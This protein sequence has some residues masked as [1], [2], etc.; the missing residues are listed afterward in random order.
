MIYNNNMN[1][2]RT[3]SLT[4]KLALGFLLVGI[5]A[6]SFRA[7]LH[8]PESIPTGDSAWELTI[9]V[10]ISSD[11]KNP[12]IYMAVPFDSVSNRIIG[13]SFTHPGFDL[14]RVTQRKDVAAREV[15]AVARGK[16]ELSLTGEFKIH[17]SHGKRWQKWLKGS[18]LMAPDDRMKFLEVPAE[19]IIDDGILRT[20]LKS[21]IKKTQSQESLIEEIF[22][23]THREIQSDKTV[24]FES[25]EKTLIQKRADALGKANAMIALCR[26]GNI[27]ARLVTGVI[28][29][30]ILGADVHHWVEVYMNEDWVPYD[31]TVGHSGAVPTSYLKLKENNASLRT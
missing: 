27:P 21:L 24:D 2:F 30:E 4:I 18:N 13:Q 20:T 26:A 1:I 11:D 15:I 9:T 22:N 10:N 5:L 23:F 14:K 8:S 31:P 7:F 17:I 28:V 19:L 6:L 25:V 3:K 12:T 29:Q 16:G